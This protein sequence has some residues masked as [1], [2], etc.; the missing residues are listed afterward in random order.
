MTLITKEMVEGES[1]MGVS[2]M[3]LKQQHN[4]RRLDFVVNLAKLKEE[5]NRK[6]F[7]HIMQL[8][9]GVK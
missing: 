2:R 5:A 9:L 3:G 4:A 1:R 6:H 8:A 7:Q